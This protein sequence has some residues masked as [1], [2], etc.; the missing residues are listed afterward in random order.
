MVP[1]LL[2]VVLDL[3]LVVLDLPFDLL[4]V[5]LD[6]P[7]CSVLQFRAFLA[8]SWVAANDLLLVALDLPSRGRSRTTRGSSRATRGRSRATRVDQ[9]APQREST[10]KWRS[11]TAYPFGGVMSQETGGILFQKYCLREEN[12]LSL[13]EFWVKL[14][15]FCEKLDEFASA[16]V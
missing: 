4:L 14:G 2:L 1:D 12:S 9:E 8:S 6:L 16:H 11:R 15:E 10:K 3:P 13:T 5:V 7:F